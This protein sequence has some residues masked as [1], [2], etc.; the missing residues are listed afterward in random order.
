[1]FWLSD[2]VNGNPVKKELEHTQQL[3]D[4]STPRIESSEGSLKHLL[5]HATMTTKFYKSYLGVDDLDQFSIINKN[6]IRENF[7]DFA[8]SKFDLSKCRKVSTSGSTGSPF[9]VYH[10]KNK[11][12]KNIADNIYFSSKSNYKIGDYLVYVKIWSDSFSLKQR[13]NFQLK[14]MHPLSVFSL[15]DEEIKMFIDKLN[16]Q[17]SEVCFIGYASSFEKICKYI[18]R[19]GVNPIQFKTKSIITISEALNEYTRNAVTN[20]FGIRPLSRYSNNEN[21]IIAQQIGSDDLKFKINDSSYIVEIFDL[22]SDK[23]LNYGQRGRIVITDLYN[24]ATPLIRY[25]TGDVGVMELDESGKPYFTEISGRKLDLLYDT[26]GR[27][28]PSHLSAKM[29]KYG[30]F[31][32]FQLVQKSKTTYAVN[33]NTD[34]PIDENALVKEYKSYLGS[35]AQIIINYVDEI[36][37]LNS[38]KRREVVNE[39]YNTI[40]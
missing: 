32:Q 20:Y 27:L 31:K 11:L 29:C 30:E 12:R 26:K 8:S 33:L 1:M 6:I 28:V 15:S 24:L 7:A 19:L 5:H 2:T 17:S 10:N 16:R 25:D 18:D 37:L 9:S 14:N 21:G 4:Q 23:K 38:G 13:A 36:P 3:L 34:K 40:H 35:D 22:D 39:Y